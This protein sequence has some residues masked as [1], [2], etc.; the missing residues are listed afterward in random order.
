LGETQSLHTN[1]F[2][3]A[4]ALPGEDAVRLALRT[5]QVIAHET[6]V[7][8]TID[9]LGGS[10]YLEDLTNR[11]EAEAYDYFGRIERLG[12]V[13]DAI[14]ENFFQREIADA[15]C[16]YQ[17]EVEAGQRVIVGVNRYQLED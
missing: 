13:I 11:L 5:Q 15:S 17:A 3:E 16:R 12:G 2:D 10:W 1:S 7:V 14:K 8:N 6:G 4:L 9:P